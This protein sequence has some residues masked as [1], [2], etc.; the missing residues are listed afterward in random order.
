[1]EAECPG[2]YKSCESINPESRSVLEIAERLF[3][4][5]LSHQE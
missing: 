1:M 2:L 3:F 5:G 4:K